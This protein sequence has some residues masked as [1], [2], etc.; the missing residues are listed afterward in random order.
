M[1]P[2]GRELVRLAPTKL[3]PPLVEGRT[4]RRDRIDALLDKGKRITLVVA[5][6][7]YGKTVAVAQWAERATAPVAWLT[8][9]A[10]DRPAERFWRYV[11]AAFG[12]AVPTLG[13]ETIQSLDDWGPRGSR[14]SRPCSLSW[15]RSA[16]R[17]CS[18]WTTFIWSP[19]TPRWTS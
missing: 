19:T 4:E 1:V 12:S 16:T 5:P 17:W 18:F 8:I 2:A 10:H 3:R 6:A 11:A 14:S 13:D 15:V 7:G 9:D